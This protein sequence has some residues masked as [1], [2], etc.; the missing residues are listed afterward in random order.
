M[1]NRE[2][3]YE[4]F[5]PEFQHVGQQEILVKELYAAAATPSTVF[6]YADRYDEYRRLENNIAGDFRTSNANFWHMAR[7]FGSTPTLNDEFVTSNPTDRIYSTTAVD[8]L[9]VM[10]HHNIQARRVVHTNGNPR[11]LG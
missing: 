10:V 3:K 8:Q 1:W 5:N 9:Q 11:G 6:G 2:T 7:V 4:Y